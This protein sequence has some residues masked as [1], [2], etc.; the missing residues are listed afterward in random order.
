MVKKSYDL[1]SVRRALEHHSTTGCLSSVTVDEAR[2]A[3]QGQR[4]PFHV[5]GDAGYID[6]YMTLDEAHGLCI[7]LR[8]AEIRYAAHAKVAETIHA[9]LDGSEWS[10]ETLDDIREV[11]ERAH[12]T[13]SDP[14]LESAESES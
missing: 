2:D 5:Q 9:I 6:Q 7:G 13:I 11:F 12:W 3:G 4:R 1:D 10:A 14:N 8:L